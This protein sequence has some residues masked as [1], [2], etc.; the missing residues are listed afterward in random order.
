MVAG[1]SHAI[2]DEYYGGNGE[3]NISGAS[4]LTPLQVKIFV[5]GGQVTWHECR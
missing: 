5:F 3:S 2:D 4:L 1:P